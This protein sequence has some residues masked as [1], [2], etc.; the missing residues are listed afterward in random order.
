MVTLSYLIK[1]GSRVSV[2]HIELGV[3]E[4]MLLGVFRKELFLIGDGIALTLCAVIAGQA[5]VERGDPDLVVILLGCC[6]LLHDAPFYPRLV[7]PDG[8]PKHIPLLLYHLDSPLTT[9]RNCF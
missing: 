2:V 4:S 6:F 1:I 8:Q 7:L 3:G 5:A 9:L